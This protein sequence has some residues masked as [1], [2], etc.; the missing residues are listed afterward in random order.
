MNSLIVFAA[1]A[2]ICL[3]ALKR[4]VFFLRLFSLV[5]KAHQASKSSLALAS[6]PWRTMLAAK[7]QLERRFSRQLTRV[8]MIK[9]IGKVAGSF[10]C[11]SGR[12]REQGN[13][14]T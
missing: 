6:Q 4:A 5:H 12:S 2:A 13:R 3:L 7:A 14:S 8:I 10:P 9:S 11:R 1:M